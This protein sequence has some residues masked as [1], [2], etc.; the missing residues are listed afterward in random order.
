M[1]SL[2]HEKICPKCDSPN[3]KTWD[4]LDFEQKFLI[5]RLPASADFTRRERK[6]HRFCVRCFYEE[7]ETQTKNV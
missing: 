7:I 5:E 6:K 3:M 2:E 4:E 1:K